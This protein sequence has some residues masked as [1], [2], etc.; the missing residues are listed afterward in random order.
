D[1]PQSVLI[2]SLVAGA[3]GTGVVLV[4]SLAIYSD[5]VSH[6]L[7]HALGKLFHLV[8]RSRQDVDVDTTIQDQRARMSTVVRVYGIKMTLCLARM[9]GLCCVLCWVACRSVSLCLPVYM[10]FVSLSYRQFLSVVAS[11]PGGLGISEVGTAG[12]L[13]AFGGDP[14]AAS[15]AA[16]LYAQ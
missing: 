7:G 8:R 6:W 13:V 16:L 12:V 2:A 5:R 4:F 15:A 11:S 1:A 10:L 14:G 3:I 9:S